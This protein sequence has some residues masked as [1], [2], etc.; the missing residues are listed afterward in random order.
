LVTSVYIYNLF[1][2][3]EFLLPI[4][5]LIAVRKDYGLKNLEIIITFA[6]FSGFSE[7][8]LNCSQRWKRFINQL[9]NPLLEIY[10][11]LIHKAGTFPLKIE[12]IMD[13]NYS[14]KVMI[15]FRP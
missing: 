13:S 3:Y 1:N 6:I 4:T 15:P 11:Y 2:S 12:A 7:N 8:P 9:A 14:D 5:Y 10:A